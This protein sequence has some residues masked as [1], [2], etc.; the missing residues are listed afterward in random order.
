MKIRTEICDFLEKNRE[1][2]APFIDDTM[3]FEYV[4]FFF[5]INFC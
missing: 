2:F 1:S 5:L 4:T 3:T